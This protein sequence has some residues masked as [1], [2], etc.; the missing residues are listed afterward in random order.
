[1]CCVQKKFSHPQLFFP[2]FDY[3]SIYSN[4][5]T[6]Y[7]HYSNNCKYYRTMR[8]LNLNTNHLHRSLTSTA[9]RLVAATLLSSVW[10]SSG[11]AMMVGTT[12]AMMS[13]ATMP[14]A[15]VMM[16]VMATMTTTVQGAP[17]HPT[18]ITT[19][20][21]WS[22]PQESDLEEHHH[23]EHQ[24]EPEPWPAIEWLRQDPRRYVTTAGNG[25][26]G[27]DDGGDGDRDGSRSS[28]K[29]S[30]SSD[31]RDR[32]KR[33]RRKR[34]RDDHDD[35]AFD[36][37][38][39]DERYLDV[40]LPRGASV[41]G[42]SDGSDGTAFGASPSP[43]VSSLSTRKRRPRHHHHHA[44]RRSSD[45]TVDHNDDYNDDRAGSGSG[46]ANA[47]D[48]GDNTI[49]AIAPAPDTAPAIA[50]APERL[51][52]S[53][54]DDA[55]ASEAATIAATAAI[56]AAREPDYWHTYYHRERRPFRWSY[57]RNRHDE[58]P[59]AMNTVAMHRGA[60]SARS[61]M[62]TAR[63]RDMDGHGHG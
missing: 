15:T 26:G 58:D 14:M 3:H 62:D 45:D 10:A 27:P 9:A 12:T 41:G 4:Y 35:L 2:T 47:D 46:G 25:G 19:P 42:A 1:M 34:D 43:R 31:K 28:S 51:S 17:V 22:P 11:V 48:R 36:Y 61:T 53:S 49:A 60:S 21:Q 44:H 32:R 20:S 38:P 39:G 50:P 16:T 18:V 54:A 8:H 40:L 57:L 63:A 56:A 29:S 30:P 5:S 33:D 13:M 37:Q 59:A 52:L 23:P 24:V 55:T 6:D 7:H